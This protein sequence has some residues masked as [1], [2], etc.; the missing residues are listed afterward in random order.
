[1]ANYPVD[2]GA[3]AIY[4]ISAG[5]VIKKGPGRLVCVNVTTAGTTAGSA[6][7]WNSTTSPQQLIYSIP[8]NVGLYM[9]KW[10]VTSGIVIVPGA[11][12]VVSVSFT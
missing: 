8:N 6:Y 7:D 10:P 5:T 3:A 11:T 12:Q 4:N 9:L 1:M 2:D